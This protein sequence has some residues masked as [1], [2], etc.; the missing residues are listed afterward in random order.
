[1]PNSQQVLAIV[2]SVV[3]VV[4]SMGLDGCKKKESQAG[5]QAQAPTTTYAMPTP[6][7]L[8]QL[9]APIALF[10]DNLVAIVLASSTSQTRSPRPGSGCSR[11]GGSRA[12]S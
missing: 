12:R 2:T 10:P 11:T 8:Y 7:Q 6:D 9:V 3:L 4:S 5:Q 1:M